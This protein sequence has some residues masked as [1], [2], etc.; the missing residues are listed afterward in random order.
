[1]GVLDELR[2]QIGRGPDMWSCEEVQDEINAFEAAHPGLIE[3][4]CCYCGNPVAPDKKRARFP[5]VICLACAKD[6]E[7]ANK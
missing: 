1:M 5:K 3:L 7:E 6:D 2:N 4:V